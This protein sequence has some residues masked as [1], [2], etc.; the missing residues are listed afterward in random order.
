MV[1]RLR[2]CPLTAKSAVRFRMGLPF[3]RQFVSGFYFFYG[4][5]VDLLFKN[6]I[7]YQL[8]KKPK[9]HCIFYKILLWKTDIRSDFLMKNE[10]TIDFFFI[11]FIIIIIIYINEWKCFTGIFLML[12]KQ[13]LYYEIYPKSCGKI[14]CFNRLNY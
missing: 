1:K 9:H 2:R 10:K 6:L 3:P 8:T 14:A 7:P 12:D 11:F 5:F 13:L 4:Y